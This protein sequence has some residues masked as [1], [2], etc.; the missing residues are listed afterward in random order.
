MAYD[1]E[2]EARYRLGEILGNRRRYMG[3]SLAEA[4][5]ATRLPSRVID[6]IDSGEKVP[7]YQLM[8]YC[9]YLGMNL[10]AVKTR[11][12]KVPKYMRRL[13]EDE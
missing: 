1:Y 3:E 13:L 6:D 9:K 5:A 12:A 7:E 11:A 4:A 8:A 10:E 2:Q